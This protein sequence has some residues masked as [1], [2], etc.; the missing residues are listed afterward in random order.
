[1]SCPKETKSALLAPGLLATALLLNTTINLFQ[2]MVKKVLILFL[3]FVFL[4]PL[5]SPDGINKM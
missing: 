5:I 3:F 2:S 4:L 1:M